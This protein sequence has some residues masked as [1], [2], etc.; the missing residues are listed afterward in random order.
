MYFKLTMVKQFFHKKYD[1]RKFDHIKGVGFKFDTASSRTDN[2]NELYYDGQP[3]DI[4]FTNIEQ[5]LTFVKKYGQC[6]IKVDCDDNN[7]ITILNDY[8]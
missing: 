3:L 7:L 1:K 6:I 2:K 4:E 5:L 8:L